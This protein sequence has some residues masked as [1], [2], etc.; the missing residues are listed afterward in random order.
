MQDKMKLVMTYGCDKGSVVINGI[1]FSN[2]F[3]DGE[4]GVY[5]TEEPPTRCHEVGFVDFRDVAKIEVWK[6]DCDP[7]SGIK[8]GREVFN[9]CQC[10]SFGFDKNGNLIFW[11][12]F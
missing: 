5:F 8:L 1:S 4:H 11:K 10:V 2:G 12:C 3:G 7:K 6:H 9:W